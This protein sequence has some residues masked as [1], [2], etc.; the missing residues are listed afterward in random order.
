MLVHIFGAKSLPCCANKALL[1]TADDNE[2]KYGR[3]VA[4]IVRCNFYVDDLLKSTMTTEKATE[5]GFET[6]RSSCIRWIPSNKV[7]E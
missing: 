7:H 2:P 5:P 6:N 4:D 1:Q 3:E